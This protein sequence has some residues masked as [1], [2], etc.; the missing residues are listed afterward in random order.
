[1][2]GASIIEHEWGNALM[3]R[4][5]AAFSRCLAEEWVLTFSDGSV[6]TKPMAL[7]DLKEGALRIESFR[8]DNVEA[9]VYGDAAIVLGVITERSKFRDEDTSGK[10]YGYELVE[11]PFELPIPKNAHSVFSFLIGVS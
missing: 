4:D 11:S 7:A 10:R 9:R 5:V 3:M 8:L 2:A 1:V 6:V